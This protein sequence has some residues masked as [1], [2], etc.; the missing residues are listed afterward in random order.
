LLPFRKGCHDSRRE[1]GKLFFFGAFR[2]NV[3]HHLG[4]RAKR[5]IDVLSNMV[6]H[7]HVPGADV[8][9]ARRYFITFHKSNAIFSVNVEP[10]GPLGSPHRFEKH[11]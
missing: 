9:V 1:F 6:P 5:N 3:G 8:V 11:F 2:V 7:S 10:D 4:G